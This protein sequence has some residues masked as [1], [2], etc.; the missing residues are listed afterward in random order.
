MD[1]SFGVVVESLKS[2][3][4]DDPRDE[5]PLDGAAV[6]EDDLAFCGEDDL[7]FDV[8]DSLAFDGEDDLSVADLSCCVFVVGFGGVLLSSCQSTK[9][10]RFLLPDD[11]LEGLVADELAGL[12]NSAAVLLL[13]FGTEVDDGCFRTEAGTVMGGCGA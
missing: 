4:S 12:V 1:E 6:D 9:S 2:N 3:K 11:A 13:L 7:V 10:N 8:E 5:V